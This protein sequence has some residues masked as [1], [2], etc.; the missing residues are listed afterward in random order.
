MVPSGAMA[1]AEFK[2]TRWTPQVTMPGTASGLGGH[3]NWAK[4]KLPRHRSP[5]P[6]APGVSEATVAARAVLLGETFTRYEAGGF[7]GER[8]GDE[9]VR[10]ELG[11][12]RIDARHQVA[13]G[14][15]DLVDRAAEARN[16]DGVA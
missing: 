8:A 5:A 15:G 4:R 12:E 13:V 9:G 2:A 16:V 7:R 10:V 11:A 14:L 1:G 6:G 3:G